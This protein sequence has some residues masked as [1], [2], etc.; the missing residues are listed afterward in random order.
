MPRT[1]MFTHKGDKVIFH[2]ITTVQDDNISDNIEEIEEA[3]R[4]ITEDDEPS[5][6]SCH[7]LHP[8]IVSQVAKEELGI[9]LR[10]ISCPS[11]ENQEE[12]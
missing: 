5:Q 11:V 2:F 1:M 7:E 4:R 6:W 8:S 12:E 10:D 9:I 3:L